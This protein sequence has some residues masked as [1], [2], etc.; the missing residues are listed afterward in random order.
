MVLF[1]GL[2]GRTAIGNAM[3]T[4]RTAYN[5]ISGQLGTDQLK[6]DEIDLSIHHLN[7]LIDGY[8]CAPIATASTDSFSLVR[9]LSS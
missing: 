8:A 3:S 4:N 1:R 5:T 2:F 9:L 7:E 6:C